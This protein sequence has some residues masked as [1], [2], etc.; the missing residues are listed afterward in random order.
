MTTK[1]KTPSPSEASRQGVIHIT[2]GLSE[3]LLTN[4]RVLGFYIDAK[5]VEGVI[6]RL[7]KEITK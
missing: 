1:P 5:G 4:L 7:K 2:I 6:A 3:A